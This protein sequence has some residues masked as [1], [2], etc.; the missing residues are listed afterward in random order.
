MSRNK[1]RS[2][3]FIGLGAI[4]VVIMSTVLHRPKQCSEIPQ[5]ELWACKAVYRLHNDDVS[6]EGTFVGLFPKLS[7]GAERIIHSKKDVTPFLLAALKD[8][9]RFAVAHVVLTYR[10]GEHNNSS[11]AW[12]GLNVQIDADGHA[13]YEGNNLEELHRF[14]EKKLAKE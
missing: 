7:S 4:G 9:D 10:A 3:L 2:L 8:P 11:V 6:W 12:N 5:S 13:T 1:Y 14:W